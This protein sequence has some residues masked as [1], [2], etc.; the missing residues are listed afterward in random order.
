MTPRKATMRHRLRFSVGVGCCPSLR[1][2]TELYKRFV[3]AKRSGRRVDPSDPLVLHSLKGRFMSE[4]T[5]A[6]P[7]RRRRWILGGAI[8]GA[9]SVLAGATALVGAHGVFG[10]HGGPMNPEMLAHR[11]E[12]GVKFMLADVDA[13]AEQKAQVTAILQ[14]AAKDVHATLAGQHLATHKEIHEILSAPSIDRARLET[15]RENHLRLADDASR[16]I[17]QAIADS[18]EVLTP[19]QRAQLA[20]TLEQHGRWR[21]GEE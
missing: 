7:S 11:I 2:V 4:S 13:T 19:Q 3:R 16:R 14:A 21:H 5:P 17:L 10:R 18:A 9:L 1:I 15:L 12:H 20:A 6:T 8:L